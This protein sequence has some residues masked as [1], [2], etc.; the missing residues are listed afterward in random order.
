[1]HLPTKIEWTPLATIEAMELH[2]YIAEDSLAAANRQLGLLLE[3]IQS[4][5]FFP[6][7][8]RVGRVSGTRE[9]VVTGTPY[10]VAYRLEANAIQ[11]LSILHGAR[12]WPDSFTIS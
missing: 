3:A 11:I 7:K 12:R 10:V 2:R 5:S 9:L 1:L 6:R 4:P 8:G